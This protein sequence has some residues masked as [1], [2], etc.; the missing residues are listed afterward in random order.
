MRGASP[1]ALRL[2]SALLGAGLIGAWWAERPPAGFGEVPTAAAAG[3]TAPALSGAS[4][5]PAAGVP[6]APAQDLVPGGVR[7]RP[8]APAP[9]V[10][11]AGPVALRVPDLGIDA[12][13]VD[14][15]VTADGAMQV[16]GDGDLVGWYR[17][18][19][20]PGGPGSAVL[21][22][23]VDT[24]REGPGALHPLAGAGQGQVVEV[25]LADGAVR[26]FAVTAR[27]QVAKADLPVAQLFDR[28]GGPR[29]VLLTCG[30]RFDA[31]RG[32]YEDNV[33]VVAEP[34]P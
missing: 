12:R 17:F 20:V 26:R 1:R 10:P 33:V 9:P 2:V 23:H 29:L 21:A 24:A 4:G 14:V 6:G 30:G 25:V 3:T 11:V 8:A 5:T 28:S 31:E 32:R 18:G 22:G 19:P 16:P 34:V 27:R 13:V 7:V 15:G